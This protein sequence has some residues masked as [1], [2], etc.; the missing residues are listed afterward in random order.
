[1]AFFLFYQVW[2]YLFLWQLDQP[3]AGDTGGLFFPKAMTHTFV[4]LY[5]QQ[6]C[7]AGLFFLAQDANKKP[8]CIV[9]GALTIVLIFLTFGYHMIILDS[10]N[11]LKRALP[12]SLANK[13]YGVAQDGR[14][15]STPSEIDTVP[16]DR[17]GSKHPLAKKSMDGKPTRGVEEHP[18]G[19]VGQKDFVEDGKGSSSAGPEMN[20]EVDLAVDRVGEDG[21]VGAAGQDDAYKQKEEPADFNHPALQEQQIVWFPQD[22]LGVA[23]AEVAELSKSQIKAATTNAGMDEKGKITIT[24]HPPGRKLRTL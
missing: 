8:S 1:V 3:A 23:D 6:V 20:A 11:P 24:G 21:R 17:Y 16:E 22:T 14:L 4:G 13:S 19:R 15:S 7:M 18:M 2:K 12:L 5:I 10:Y 9:E